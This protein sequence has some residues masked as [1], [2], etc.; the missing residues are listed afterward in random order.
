MKTN[1]SDVVASGE[2]V[3]LLPADSAAH[4]TLLPR[5]GLR[6]LATAGEEIGFE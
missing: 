5:R 1:S 3:V 2:V 4:N 6:P